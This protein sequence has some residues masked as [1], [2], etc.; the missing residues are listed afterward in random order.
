MGRAAVVT[1]KEEGWLC[2]TGSFFLHLKQQIEPEFFLLCFKSPKCIH[3]MVNTAKGATM[4]NLNHGLLKSLELFLPTK[5][6]QLEIIKNITLAKEK[7]E[8]MI[9]YS[10]QGQNLCSELR[11][12]ILQEAFS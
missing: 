8:R 7:C 4:Q 1:A 2:G 9:S 3:Q 11:K 5:E 12:S 6:K 10:Q